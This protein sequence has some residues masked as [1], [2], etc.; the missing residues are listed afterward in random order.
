[1]TDPEASRH[2][3]VKDSDQTVAGAEVSASPDGWRQG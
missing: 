1:M 2:I 3:E